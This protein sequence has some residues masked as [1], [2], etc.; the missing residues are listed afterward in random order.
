MCLGDLFAPSKPD[1]PVA[2]PLPPP[3]EADTSAAARTLKALE[4]GRRGRNS[5]LIDPALPP[6][7]TS[8]GAPDLTL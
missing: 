3:P 1:P 7:N 5:L 2:P 8:S 6:T 4:A